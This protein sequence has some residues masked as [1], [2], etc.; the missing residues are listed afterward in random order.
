MLH[1]TLTP[2]S[3]VSAILQQ[4]FGSRKAAPIG[5]GSH[6]LDYRGF[7]FFPESCMQ[8]MEFWQY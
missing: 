7:S 1:W 4:Q 8:T 3:C 6:G 2:A 5:S